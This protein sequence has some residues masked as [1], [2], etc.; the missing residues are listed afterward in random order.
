M[1]IHIALRPFHLAYICVILTIYWNTLY[2]VAPMLTP[3][4]CKHVEAVKHY[5]DSWYEWFIMM[6]DVML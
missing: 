4:E 1:I 5:Y 6:R 2:K 3:R